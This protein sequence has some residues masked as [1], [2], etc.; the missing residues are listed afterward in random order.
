MRLY[1]VFFPYDKPRIEQ[2]K[3]MDEL[4]KALDGKYEIVVYEAPSGIG[5][6]IATLSVLV[7][8][9]LKH[10]LKL[11]YCCRT[12]T[13]MSR[14]IEE[15]RVMRSK[16]L[17]VSGVMLRGRGELCFNTRIRKLP[18]SVMI[19]ACERLRAK[20][21]CTYDL[22]FKVGEWSKGLG[23]IGDIIHVDDIKEYAYKW[24]ICPYE[25]ALW[26]CR[27]ADIITLSYLY[28]LDR[29][30]R[31]ILFWTIGLGEED[32][33]LVFDEA[34]NLYD[35]AIE[36]SSYT[37]SSR[38][39]EHI[40]KLI[41]S[42]H[43]S[44][45]DI[46]VKY[47]LVKILKFLIKMLRQKC[48]R[49]RELEY[50]SGSFIS[51]FER[52]TNQ[53]YAVFVD[54][55]ADYAKKMIRSRSISL[56]DEAKLKTVIDFLNK[57]I[58]VQNRPEYI[59]ILEPLGEE[60]F[61]YSIISL[62]P[63]LCI[64]DAIETAKMTVMMSATLSP[65]DSYL[66]L[67][68]IKHAYTFKVEPSYKGRVKAFVIKGVTSAFKFRSE[69]MIKTYAEIVRLVAE[70]FNA[71][72]GVFVPSYDFCNKL[73]SKL[74]V[75][76]KK[77]YV[78]RREMKA[79]EFEHLIMKFKGEYKRGGALLIGVYGGK[80]SEGVDYPGRTLEILLLIGVPYPEPNAKTLAQ[81][82]YFE[83]KYGK[84]KSF[85]YAFILPA[86]RRVNQA[87]GR[88]VRS[89]KDYGLV[90]LLD[91]RFSKLKKYV[92]SW[93][94]IVGEYSVQEIKKVLELVSGYLSRFR[95]ELNNHLR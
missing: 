30:L 79:S 25:F 56:I 32:F 18:Y 60:E 46:N 17:K 11:L 61:R 92:V 70:S 77:V 88:L 15:L 33:I 94:D 90:L 51:D 71:N 1:D 9:C 7:P 36:T 64:A 65:M 75:K 84:E 43:V 2:A 6:T 72:I 38:E 39:L 89:P 73:L 53:P 69:E 93:V 52:A 76:R 74:N 55:L 10:G 16:G 45:V 29:K 3:V 26:L 91:E 24:N 83:I 35:V 81:E 49:H 28:I 66:E 14:V 63:S 12:H 40:I 62:D 59:E 4:K 27:R 8:Y 42:V 86:M 19:E 21:A 41:K 87:I 95:S 22:N 5:K 50:D 78:E 68:G 23:E 80:A 57:L 31:D 58:D 13:Q 85:E 54:T 34:H 20:G 67:Y 44:S 48:L 37:L 82:R 47:G